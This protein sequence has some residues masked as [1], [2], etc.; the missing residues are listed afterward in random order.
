MVGGVEIPFHKESADLLRLFGSKE[1]NR[2]AKIPHLGT[3]TFVFDSV[4]HSRWEY[5]M[6][7]CFLIDQIAKNFKG[8]ETLSLAAPVR[9]ESGFEFSSGS[10]L[11]KSW[12]LLVSLGHIRNVYT[13]EK[14]LLLATNKKSSLRHWLK[15]KI[16]DEYIRNQF[17]LCLKN[18]DVASFHLFLAWIRLSREF[19]HQRSK[20]TAKVALK[21]LIITRNGGDGVSSTELLKVSRLYQIHSTI[22][23]L[24]IGSLDSHHS[25]QP[26]KLNPLATVFS[27]EFLAD[28]RF[29]ETLDRL[30]ADQAESIYLSRK[31]VAC[32]KGLEVSICKAISRQ[33]DN[34]GDDETRRLDYYKTYI[35]T[36]GE[37]KFQPF[38]SFLRINIE[39]K[40][41]DFKTAKTYSKLESLLIGA[42]KKPSGCSVSIRE[43]YSSGIYFVDFLTD[44]NPRASSIRKMVSGLCYLLRRQAVHVAINQAKREFDGITLDE[45]VL[46]SYQ[47]RLIA[48]NFQDFE[49]QW[50]QI[51]KD[52][53]SWIL[54]EQVRFVTLPEHFSVEATQ[55]SGIAIQTKDFRFENIQERI[56]ILQ[57]VVSYDPD[58]VFELRNFFNLCEAFRHCEVVIA[59]FGKQIIKNTNGR[60]IDE[61]DGLLLII[62]KGE[63]KLVIFE[64]KNILPKAKR[65]AVAMKQLDATRKLVMKSNKLKYRRKRI[66]GVGA[67]LEIDIAHPKAIYSGS[68]VAFKNS[69][70]P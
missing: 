26:L 19:L 21:S 51:S 44:I 48:R 70:P 8:H 31:A 32:A 64:A 34:L 27:E 3:A 24:A 43:E 61:W 41:F 68:D 38:A 40:F 10:E 69:T 7:R 4:R 37:R 2:L 15:K 9:L 45:E 47:N 36:G 54:G 1:R 55:S 17:D 29:E 62:D 46:R 25:H 58:R 60:D 14:S 6:L 20:K 35:D 30:I 66:K 11:L 28:D 50:T 65:E 49:D 33:W 56:E 57:N 59:N 5:L 53:L 39:K 22:R 67:Y 23:K 16:G 42:C 52:F 12:A 63:V 13:A 18:E